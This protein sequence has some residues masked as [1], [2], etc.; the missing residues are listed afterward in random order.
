MS[1]ALDQAILATD[2]ITALSDARSARDGVAFLVSL[3]QGAQSATLE[4]GG[5]VALLDGVRT[6]LDLACDGL[7]AAALQLGLE[8]EP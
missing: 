6:R 4:G 1:A 8:V 5:L 7:T 3:L 2:M